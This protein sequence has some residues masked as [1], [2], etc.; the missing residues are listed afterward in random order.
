MKVAE[1]LYEIENRESGLMMRRVFES[2]NL[3]LMKR[4]AR[5]IILRPMYEE[6][7]NIVV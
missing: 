2:L 3:R 6:A 5:F 4:L 1:K 7:G